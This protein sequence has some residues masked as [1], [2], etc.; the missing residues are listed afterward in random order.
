MSGTSC[1]QISFIF[2]VCRCRL[3]RKSGHLVRKL[4]IDFYCC[5][6]QQLLNVKMI[7]GDQDLFFCDFFFFLIDFFITIIF[8]LLLNFLYTFDER[9]TPQGRGKVFFLSLFVVESPPCLPQL[10][11]SSFLTSLLCCSWVQTS[12]ERIYC[13]IQDFLFLLAGMFTFSPCSIC[14][15]LAWK[16]LKCVLWRR[17]RMQLMRC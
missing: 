12:T 13:K 9:S 16:L 4:P 17:A 14:F 3:L 15:I 2:N 8:N 1:L 6:W 10:F 5:H 11:P 7:L